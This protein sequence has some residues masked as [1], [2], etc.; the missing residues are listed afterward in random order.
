MLIRIVIKVPFCMNP[1]WKKSRRLKFCCTGLPIL[2]RILGQ[3]SD[4][5]I[6]QWLQEF[7]P[8]SYRSVLISFNQSHHSHFYIQFVYK[9]HFGT[10][11]LLAVVFLSY[12]WECFFFQYFID[13]G[14]IFYKYCCFHTKKLLKIKV[15][16]FSINRMNNF[17]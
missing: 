15:G 16:L 4:Q 14:I 11:I 17:W 2:T 8:S 13:K 7:W 12:F 3:N 5:K 1:C 6:R 9:T 10:W